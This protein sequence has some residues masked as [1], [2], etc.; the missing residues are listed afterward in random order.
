VCE[1]WRVATTSVES[2]RGDGGG[3][4][5]AAALTRAGLAN[6]LSAVIERYEI[7]LALD[8]GAHRGEY[9]RILRGVGYAGPIVSYE[10]VAASFE[11]LARSSADDPG[12]SVHRMAL[13]SSDG[14]TEI[15]VS[16]CT[17]FSSLRRL[18]ARGHQQFSGARL[19]GRETVEVRRLDEVL[20]EHEP[21]NTA[22]PTLLK[23]DTQGSDLDVLEGASGVL[24]R[25]AAIQIEAPLRPIYD[26]VAS[27]DEIL[28]A[29][30]NLGFALSRVFP[31]AT[32]DRLRLI[33][34]DCV[35]VRS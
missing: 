22:A 30:T 28:K 7:G 20:A 34:V 18:N 13:G 24:D 31:V 1:P 12:W 2:Q 9:G 3:A 5:V 21:A 6:H 17:E 32:D 4:R 14:E 25:I 33:E 19:T 23:I 16:E 11:E 15:N 35:A 10:P 26:G 29:L 8:A 27:F